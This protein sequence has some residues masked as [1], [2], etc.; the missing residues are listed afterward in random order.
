MPPLYVI[1]SEAKDLK[2]RSLGFFAVFAAL[3]DKVRSGPLFHCS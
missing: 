2:M 3:N 1:Q